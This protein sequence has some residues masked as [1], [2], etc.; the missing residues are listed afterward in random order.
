MINDLGLIVNHDTVTFIINATAELKLN[1]DS[2]YKGVDHLID[3][4]GPAVFKVPTEAAIENLGRS[5][6][7]AAVYLRQISMIKKSLAN[8]EL[9]IRGY[10]S[11][12]SLAIKELQGIE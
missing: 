5:K 3:I 1:V 8:L 12:C 9:H 7:Q 11:V 10:D 4:Y 6:N 2:I